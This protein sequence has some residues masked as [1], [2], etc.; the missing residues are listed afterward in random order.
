MYLIGRHALPV[1][2][3]LVLLNLVA[4]K[5]AIDYKDEGPLTPPPAH[6]PESVEEGLPAD[7]TDAL[8]DIEGGA[9]GDATGVPMDGGEVMEPETDT[10]PPSSSSSPA[11]S[12]GAASAPNPAAIDDEAL[13]ESTR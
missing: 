4:C 3:G 1:L 7:S 2:L 12:A 13:L 9:G 5:P 10:A 8:E 6:P 11:P